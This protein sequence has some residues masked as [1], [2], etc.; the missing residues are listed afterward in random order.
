[1]GYLVESAPAEGGSLCRGGRESPGGP[2][3]R[4]VVRLG[5]VGG[6]NEIFSEWGG[7]AQHLDRGRTSL[8][9]DPP[10]G[11]MP[12]YSPEGITR[13]NGFCEWLRIVGRGR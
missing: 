9:I 13:E 12:Q 3:G 11:R 2:Y 10:G 8:I 7:T 5:V 4:D 6:C 1:M